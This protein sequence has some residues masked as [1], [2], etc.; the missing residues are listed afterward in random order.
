MD[1]SERNEGFQVKDRRRFTS[2]GD[3]KSEPEEPRHSAGI[4]NA[5]K[6]TTTEA[7]REGSAREGG[8]G[9][10][11]EK[12][13][14]PIDF[15]GL[16]ISLANTALFQLGLVTAPGVEAKKDLPAARQT[17]DIIALLETKTQGNLSDEEKR[18]VSET[19]FQLRMAFVES[20]K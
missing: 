8:G 12:T 1:E 5:E 7:R 3:V 14:P 19:L 4:E 18:I 15:S 17:I 16:I 11:G 2:E 20:S 10:S 6:A 9:P 13:L